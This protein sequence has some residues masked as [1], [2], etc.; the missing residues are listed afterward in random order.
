MLE[1]LARILSS[2]ESLNH[3]KVLS[4]L[5]EGVEKARISPDRRRITTD[6]HGFQP[7]P[8]VLCRT[9]V[10]FFRVSYDDSM[11]AIGKVGPHRL[12]V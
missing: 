12:V 6:V 10:Q 5:S 3:F 1:S 9:K 8:K 2:V 7:S 11:R 4:S